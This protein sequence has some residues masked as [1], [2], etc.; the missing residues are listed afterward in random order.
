MGNP[1]LDYTR[2]QH[3]II[4]QDGVTPYDPAE[5]KLFCE[6][7]SRKNEAGGKEVRP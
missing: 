5:I 2:W 3:D 6:Y 7:G 1:A 4:R